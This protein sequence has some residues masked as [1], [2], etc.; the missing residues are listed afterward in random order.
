MLKIGLRSVLAHR[1][2]FAL[3]TVAVMLGIAF[4]G[5]AMVF[6]DT[7]ATALKKQ[8]AG[9]TADI[10]VTPVDPVES[11]NGPPPTL[12]SAVVSEV[13][14]V[15]GVAEADA[16]LLVSD[17]QIRKPD[18]STIDTYGLATYG[19]G[20]PHAISTSPFRLIDGQQPFGTAE[21]ALDQSTASKA[22]YA[23][24]DQVRIVSAT[25]AV[26]AKL[27]G[28]ITPAQAG[29]AA[30][31]P[32]VVFDSATAQL[33]LLGKPGWTSIAVTL[34]PDADTEQ[35]RTAIA[36]A[37]GDPYNVRTA[38]QVEAD[39]ETALDTTFGGFS[40]I[41]LMFAGLALFVGAFLIV[42]TFAMQ[43]AQR[44]REL[45]MLRAIGASRGQ[46]TR[47]VLAEALVIG[48]IG[49]TLGLLLGIAVAAGIH[50]AYQ[51]LGAAIP[52]AGL[53]I[54]PATIIACY[55][56]GA[57][58]TLAAAYPAARRAGRLSPMAALRDGATIPER[59][60]LIRLLFGGFLL[61]MAGCLYA[62]ANH[63]GGMP[64]AV[65][66][67]LASAMA[68]LGIV[69]T[70][71]LVSRYAV[72]AL[73]APFGRKAAVTLG[74]RNA[75]RNPRRT[76]ATASALMISVALISGLV[77]IAASAKA[78]IDASIAAAIGTSDLVIG[79]S[80]PDTFSPQVADRV[81]K[82]GEVAAVHQ[83][84]QQDGKVD[85]I[86]VR[87]TGVGD[88]TLAGPISVTLDSGSLDGLAKGQAVVP[89][90]LAKTLNV[91]PGKTFT[92]VTTSG[93]HKLTVAGILSPN[94][95]LNAIV[96]ALPTYES[97]GGAPA[98]SLLYVDVADG[99]S[100]AQ[101]S[102]A[103]LSEL[104]DY[105]SIQVRDQ[106]AYAA[107]AR[108]P[109]NAAAGVIGMLLALAVLI[110]ILG[111]V[112]TLALGVV[113]R[114]RE[115]GLLRAIG[116][117]RPQLR[118]MLR[119]ESIAVTLLGALLGLLVGVLTAAA[120]QRV[121]VDDGLGV[122][123]IP[124]LQLIGAMLVSALIGVLAAVWPSRRAARLNVLQAIATE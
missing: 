73:M 33:V 102:T 121:L 61:L 37:V 66:I 88:G 24:G 84:R 100:M 107:Q 96:V 85:D 99:T 59:S 90:T 105:P 97:F 112:N 82:L 5:G 8:F 14:A 65:L 111:I 104:K 11:R 98:D 69:L 23:I 124:V 64:G 31:A 2:R 19:A 48:L 54:T 58:L 108:G 52:S 27:T 7:L 83:V 44:S 17:V 87:L 28:I 122:L 38:A 62:V 74:R 45:A 116:M 77:V 106:Q 103:V 80:D 40:S 55:L 113:E 13:A 4:V 56:I 119:V 78:S 26:T 32:L 41:L 81:R 43:V 86:P 79:S 10:T 67:G 118:R 71:P 60:L 94:R 53:Q 117:D 72:R 123:D 22:G 29:P 34:K 15:A 46:V 1:L 101:A 95:Q 93:T 16:Q 110:A 18:G 115:I 3:C 51:Q 30:G 50:F 6:T 70:S 42:N 35:V 76:S 9:S 68:L 89:R 114:T 91:S 36:K 25:R 12:A 49:S 63:A 75:E 20:W 109:V 57:V 120:I 39:G 21:L 92:L 47:T